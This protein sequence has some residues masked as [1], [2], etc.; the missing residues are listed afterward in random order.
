MIWQDIVFGT[1]TIIFAVSLI[2]T[3]RDSQ[4]PAVKTS[5]PTAI[6]LAFFAV[7]SATLGLWFAVVAQVISCGLW[8]LLAFQRF[9]QNK[10][11]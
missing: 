1:G 10:K 6:I 3:I 11:A 2:P 4:K 5:L 7:T 9:N 8:S